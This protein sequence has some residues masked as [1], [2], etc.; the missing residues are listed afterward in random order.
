MLF[1][2]FVWVGCLL[3]LYVLLAVVHFDGDDR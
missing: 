3:V 1:D 2:W